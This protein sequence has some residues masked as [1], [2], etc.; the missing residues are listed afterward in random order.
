V[1]DHVAEAERELQRAEDVL[2]RDADWS[3][4]YR[5]GAAANHLAAAQVH[6]TLSVAQLLSNIVNDKVTINVL[7]IGR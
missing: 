4:E 5:Q 7:D 3:A 1:F 2:N 6:A